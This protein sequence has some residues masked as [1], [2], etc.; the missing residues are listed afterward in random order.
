MTRLRFVNRRR[1]TSLGALAPHHAAQLVALRARLE[2]PSD[3]TAEEILSTLYE[4]DLW[5]LIDERGALVYEA[6]TCA[7]DGGAFFYAGTH[8]L[9][10]DIVQFGV[11]LNDLEA[12]SALADADRSACAGF[13]MAMVDLSIDPDCGPSYACVT[14]RAT[15]S[16]HDARLPRVELG[17][18]WPAA[19][20]AIAP[21]DHD[22]SLRALLLGASRDRLAGLYSTYGAPSIFRRAAIERARACP[23]PPDAAARVG[24]EIHA[25]DLE[26]EP[27]HV[28]ASLAAITS[29]LDAA[30]DRDELVAVA[31]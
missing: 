21:F 8:D 1:P 11:A 15:G 18:I 5:E 9:L 25:L 28:D 31:I 13:A 3:A 2:G 4:P 20:R 24:P 17:P 26:V 12:W 14:E 27:A 7:V 10:A 22:G 29:L 30:L 19:A 6:W 23:L 16:F